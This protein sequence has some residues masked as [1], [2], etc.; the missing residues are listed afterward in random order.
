MAGPLGS[1]K[2]TLSPIIEGEYYLC[3]LAIGDML[4]AAIGAKT[5]F[6]F[7]AKEAM[8]KVKNFPLC[9]LHVVLMILFKLIMDHL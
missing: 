7:K 8:D 1:G 6:G 9:F 3:H 5:P 4:R 2:G